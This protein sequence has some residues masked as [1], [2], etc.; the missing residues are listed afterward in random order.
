MVFSLDTQNPFGNWIARTFFH[1]NYRYAE[2]GIFKNSDE[3]LMWKFRLPIQEQPNNHSSA[4]TL[5]SMPSK[6]PE[7]STERYRLFATMIRYLLTGTLSHEP[8]QLESASPNTVTDL[9]LSNDLIEFIE[10]PIPKASCL[11]TNQS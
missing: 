6:D 5:I 2:T 8:Y 11:Q 4:N 7:P 1:L 9:F 10:T 3:R